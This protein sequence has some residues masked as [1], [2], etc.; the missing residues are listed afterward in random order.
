MGTITEVWYNWDA[1]KSGTASTDSQRLEAERAAV[2]KSWVELEQIAVKP[3]V[4]DVTEVLSINDVGAGVDIKLAYYDVVLRVSPYV[5]QRLL[6]WL[7]DNHYI[8]L[9]GTLTVSIKGRSYNYGQQA[10]KEVYEA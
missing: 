5:M 2:T 4:I 3:H 10:E 6:Q 1:G 8:K 7:L 9:T